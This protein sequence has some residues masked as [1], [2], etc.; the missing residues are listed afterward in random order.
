M[1]LQ[2]TQIGEKTIKSGHFLPKE[3]WEALNNLPLDER[4]AYAKLLTEKGWTGVSI[5]Q[6][7]GITRQAVDLYVVKYPNQRHKTYT[8]EA[9]DK[10]KAKVE[11]KELPMPE[12]PTRPIYKTSL[13]EM[14][15]EVIEQLKELHEKAKQVR[16]S[17]P[18]Y[19]AEAEL[20]TKIAWE[21][22]QNGVSIY[23]IAKSLGL[24]TGALQF[25]FV[26]YGYKTSNGNSK[27]Y[28]KVQN[29]LEQGSDNVR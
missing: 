13:V 4:K 7:L 1:P 6:A 19:R 28:Q 5:A 24:T 16:S 22:Y 27:S 2:R 18:K 12:L 26:R 10:V 8:Q 17:S 3:V 20:F 9:L 21:Q 14:P 25:R 29:R 15:K 23:S 11:A